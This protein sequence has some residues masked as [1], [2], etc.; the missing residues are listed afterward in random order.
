MI[1]MFLCWACAG[2]WGMWMGGEKGGRYGGE[3]VVVMN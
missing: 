2:L 1:D 3:G